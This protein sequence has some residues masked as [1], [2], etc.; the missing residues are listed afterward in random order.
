MDFNT[1]LQKADSN[2]MLDEIV[3][4]ALHD[5]GELK[6]PPQLNRKTIFT[7]ENIA[8]EKKLP[9]CETKRIAAIMWALRLLRSYYQEEEHWEDVSERLAKLVTYVLLLIKKQQN[10]S[11]D[12]LLYCHDFCLTIREFIENVKVVYKDLVTFCLMPLIETINANNIHVLVKKSLLLFLTDLVNMD[13]MEW[14][15]DMMTSFQPHLIKLSEWVLFE[16]GDYEVQFI[17]FSFICMLTPVPREDRRR[18]AKTLFSRKPTICK[19]FSRMNFKDFDGGLKELMSVINDNRKDEKKY[20]YSLKCD[21]AIIDQHFLKNRDLKVHFSTA[22]SRLII[23]CFSHKLQP[24]TEI[25][26]SSIT[27]FEIEV[28]E[29][30]EDPEEISLKLFL[31]LKQ[32]YRNYFDKVYEYGEVC[33]LFSTRRTAE[34]LRDF[35]LPLIYPD[36]YTEVIGQNLDLFLEKMSEI[37]NHPKTIHKDME[38]VTNISRRQ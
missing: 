6:P 32:N 14:T 11:R 12:F 5:N 28:V 36:F 27:S 29:R 31:V 9:M 8:R 7:M 26:K 1:L 21:Y 37:E 33:L 4:R 35:V 38:L 25:E 24:F 2:K 15:D 10:S 17:A 30:K 20:I 3:H 18:F 16:C 19:K 13:T 22:S 34:I 23:E